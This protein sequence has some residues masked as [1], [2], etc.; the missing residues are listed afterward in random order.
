MQFRFESERYFFEG[1]SITTANECKE[2]SFNPE[3]IEEN[4]APTSPSRAERLQNLLSDLLIDIH[5]KAGSLLLL[6]KK[7]LIDRLVAITGEYKEVAA[8][9]LEGALAGRHSLQVLQK[10]IAIQNI[11]YLDKL[12]HELEDFNSEILPQKPI[13]PLEMIEPALLKRFLEI[14]KDID[15]KEGKF[16]TK[17]RTAAFCE[18]LYDKKYIMNTNTRIKTIADFAKA[19]YER[20]GMDITNSLKTAKNAQRENNV[21]NSVNGK[22]PLKRYFA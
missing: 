20:D 10:A 5:Q 9:E 3:E 12:I 14:E 22:P 1:L 2:L 7:K 4:E 17:I 11:K 19:R 16:N 15:N 13:D 8:K 6:D 21:E 18:L